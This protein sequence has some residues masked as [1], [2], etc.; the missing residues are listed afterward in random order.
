MHGFEHRN[1]CTTKRAVARW[2]EMA[3]GRPDA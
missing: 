1:P 2:L 3:G